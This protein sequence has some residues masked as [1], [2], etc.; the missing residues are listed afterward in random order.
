[1]AFSTTLWVILCGLLATAKARG[2]DDFSNNLATDLGPLLSLFGESI[3]KQYLSESTSIE[4]YII[5]ALAPIGL[6]TAVVS[7]IRVCGGKWLRSF[8]GRAQEGDAAVE[9]ELCTSTSK[10]I[11]EVFN[12]GGITRTLGKANILEIIR[13]P[14]PRTDNEVAE[15]SRDNLKKS[16]T[17][18]TVDETSKVCEDSAFSWNT[19]NM[20][21]FLVRDYL[22]LNNRQ[23]SGWS[24]SI[25]SVA[26]TDLFSNLARIRDLNGLKDEERDGP[27]G[28]YQVKPSDEHSKV[29]PNLS[30]NVGI[31]KRGPEFV[32]PVLILGVTLQLGLM[33]IAPLLSWAGSWSKDGRSGNKLS[34]QQA[35]LKYRFPILYLAGTVFM[36]AGMF[37]CAYLI[38]QITQETRYRRQNCDQG[39]RTGLFWVQAGDQVIGD[40]TYGPYAYSEDPSR[41]LLEYIISRKRTGQN[42]A[43]RYRLLTWI[44]VIA[45]LGGYI[46]QFVGLRGM[47]AWISIAQLA[48]TLMMSILRG[49]MRTQRL[50]NNGNKVQRIAGKV[51]GHELDWLTFEIWRNMR[52][53]KTESPKPETSREQSTDDQGC[54]SILQEDP[55]LNISWI[56]TSRTSPK[57]T[58]EEN[59]VRE[60]DDRGA[61]EPN[62]AEVVL[63]LRTRLG[64]LS[65]HETNFL[66]KDKHSK[67]QQ[68]DKREIPVRD[69]AMKM[70][71]ALCAM[72]DRLI[73]K[74]QA[75]VVI[76][77]QFQV[78]LLSYP[79]DNHS[80]PHT[81]KMTFHPPDL[82]A[83]RRGWSIDSLQLEAILG[84]YSWSLYQ[85]RAV[86][87]DDPRSSLTEI[88]SHEAISRAQ[89]L[90]SK[91]AN[92]TESDDEQYLLDLWLG[93]NTPE[94]QSCTLVWDD[95]IKP[96]SGTLWKRE[97]LQEEVAFPKTDPEHSYKPLP[98]DF[99]NSGSSEDISSGYVR[100][101]GWKQMDDEDKTIV[102]EGSQGTAPTSTKRNIYY[103]KSESSLI[104]CCCY[105]IFSAIL[106]ELLKLQAKDGVFLVAKKIVPN[107]GSSPTDWESETLSDLIR[108]F[109][110]NDMGSYQDALLC[111]LPALR[112]ILVPPDEEED[113][114]RTFMAIK[115]ATEYRRRS[116]YSRSW[117]I[118]RAM[119]TTADCD[120]L[121][122]DAVT[123]SLGELFCASLDSNIEGQAIFGHKGLQWLQSCW[124]K[125]K[126][127]RVV[128][129][130]E[131]RQNRLKLPAKSTLR[132]VQNSLTIHRYIMVGQHILAVCRRQDGYWRNNILSSWQ[133]RHV[134]GLRRTLK[135]IDSIRK[136]ETTKFEDRIRYGPQNGYMQAKDADRAAAWALIR[137]C[138]H[139]ALKHLCNVLKQVTDNLQKE[140]PR[141][142]SALGEPMG[143]CDFDHYDFGTT[144]ANLR[145]LLRYASADSARDLLGL[146]AAANWH[147][148][149]QTI[150]ELGV[151]PGHRGRKIDFPAGE[152][153]SFMGGREPQRTSNEEARSTSGDTAEVIRQK[154]YSLAFDQCIYYN[155]ADAARVLIE[156]GDF[157]GYDRDIILGAAKFDSDRVLRIASE[158]G[159]CRTFEKATRH[160]DRY[161][162]EPPLTSH[163]DERDGPMTVAAKCGSTKIMYMLRK[164][165][166]TSVDE[167]G[168]EGWMPIHHAAD[169][170]HWEV[171]NELAKLGANLNARDG[172]G[173]TPIM[174]M[175]KT[176]QFG[177]LEITIEQRPV[178]TLLR[179]ETGNTVLHHLLS[180]KINDE[181]IQK[182][183]EILQL[184][185]DHGLDPSVPVG[186]VTTLMT[187]A[188]AGNSHF[189]EVLSNIEGVAS[190]VNFVGPKDYTALIFAAESGDPKSVK[191]LLS[192]SNIDLG[193]Q[194]YGHWTALSLASLDGHDKVV[195][196][197]LDDDRMSRVLELFPR[198]F[199]LE[200]AAMEGH[201]ECLGLLLRDGRIDPNAEA[202][203]GTPLYSA[204]WNGH[205]DAVKVLLNDSRVDVNKSSGEDGTPLKVAVSK[206]LVDIAE[207]LLQHSAHVD[208]SERDTAREN[209]DEAMMRLPEGSVV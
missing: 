74:N 168:E 198:D 112:T 6:V 62:D 57:S 103:V 43:H 172:T 28:R 69:R 5:F 161:D 77:L 181:E 10:D 162:Q 160:R 98:M 34:L 117:R 194:H 97:C 208:Q 29:N 22:C 105:D 187:A 159:M 186:N 209:G 200:K 134:Q 115:S 203:S 73:P 56:F 25:T 53:D 61:Q 59:L 135:V 113:T 154:A 164:I 12:S 158:L 174:H 205:I 199:A 9:A 109:R 20:G 87:S 63:G 18:P 101:F 143:E 41:P 177:L 85:F 116:Q 127:K 170:G 55:T 182:S 39:T 206:N 121:I 37:G 191:A 122:Q 19:E 125:E 76:N 21:L 52:G 4:D 104:D 3:T 35:Y 14:Q 30:I 2:L 190:T 93:D 64:H 171:F 137:G 13:V 94:I 78:E 70:A 36:T 72:A 152:D 66:R 176:G 148:I 58:S 192:I 145:I 118:L 139:R 96:N 132:W 163:N 92:G 75:K 60:T 155:C 31:K 178:D 102:G 157:E 108:A 51:V 40:Q 79:K 141:N 142:L 107:L 128:S 140:T 24:K 202:H 131:T 144:R 126:E 193:Y 84:L 54:Q 111:I 151:P 130:E 90:S 50:A 136:E 106:T 65:G 95:T 1:M 167:R 147:E 47:S 138:S 68:W 188:R 183:L 207:L 80:E 179:D 67:P 81:I 88:R 100:F 173:M 49:M 89:I 166:G 189:L 175:A 204:V 110:E 156:S 23:D 83:R 119:K 8:I 165:G 149:V 153:Y 32:Y 71:K 99:S 91:P 82:A 124:I 38:G 169:Q 33:A 11:C 196:T 44:T 16:N 114:S 184:L 201:I 15:S 7:V 123:T 45:T 48:A 46:V 86:S 27:N 133:E 180:C 26:H 185:R 17:N 197:M 146:A 129:E 150:L 42:T 120:M 195:E